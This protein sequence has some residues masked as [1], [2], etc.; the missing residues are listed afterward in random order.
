MH[1]VGLTV[2]AVV[3]S[4][5][6]R[7]M[8]PQLVVVPAAFLVAQFLTWTPNFVRM[9]I[10]LLG[11]I[12]ATALST[13]IQLYQTIGEKRNDSLIWVKRPEDGRVRKALIR[14]RI[15]G[16]Y[17]QAFEECFHNV[18]L[19]E[20]SNK[21][22]SKFDR[23]YRPTT[24]YRYEREQLLFLGAQ[25]SVMTTIGLGVPTQLQIYPPLIV[26]SILIPLTLLTHPVFKSR[27]I[28]RRVTPGCYGEV[29]EEMRPHV[30]EKLG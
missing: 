3:N 8:K 19:Y 16:R 28:R 2:R 20:Y 29:T 23:L 6:R 25:L 9:M 22:K 24:Y 15:L 26:Q 5:L 4:L 10:L 17:E 12:A 30:E 11:T 13:V 21:D 1:E 7:R 18:V 27:I 14:Y